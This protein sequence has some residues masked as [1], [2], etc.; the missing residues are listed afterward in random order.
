MVEWPLL[1]D[2][3]ADFV[4]C[5]GQNNSMPTATTMQRLIFGLTV[6]LLGLE[7]T[8]RRVAGSLVEKSAGKFW[9]A[10]FMSTLT[11]T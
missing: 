9:L 2:V 5:T 10:L 3:T 4:Y 6:L 11:T 7:G 1:M 8:M